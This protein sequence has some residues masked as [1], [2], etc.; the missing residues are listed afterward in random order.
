MATTTRSR[1]IDP[2]LMTSRMFAQVFQAYV[3]CTEAIQSLIRDMVEIVND[4][5][6]TE[7]EKLMACSTIAESLFPS[8]HHGQLGVDLEQAERLD[9]GALA[10]DQRRSRFDGPPRRALRGSGPCADA[11]ARHDASPTGQRLRD[12]SARCLQLTVPS[13]PTTAPHGG[14][15]RKSSRC[16]NVRNLAGRRYPIII[17]PRPIPPRPP[18]EAGAFFAQSMP[19]SMAQPRVRQVLGDKKDGH[20]THVSTCFHCYA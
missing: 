8:R 13:E 12:W 6:A 7:D 2:E 5:S 11:R 17:P 9:A 14:E 4:P 18:I 19:H 1:E 20:T 16:R 15:N 3:E 10:R